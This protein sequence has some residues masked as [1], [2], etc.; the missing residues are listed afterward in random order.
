MVGFP[1]EF[2]FFPLRYIH[3]LLYVLKLFRTIHAAILFE[4]KV[5]CGFVIE[6]KMGREQYIIQ[7][8]TF[9]AQI[10]FTLWNFSKIACK[11]YFDEIFGVS[12]M[13]FY[14]LTTCLD[15]D[16]PWLSDLKINKKV[17]DENRKCYENQ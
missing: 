10:F 13:L 14:P 12:V 1:S 6:S 8:S 15:S 4:L 11:H 5:G 2:L 16:D 3:S 9:C 17:A 7:G